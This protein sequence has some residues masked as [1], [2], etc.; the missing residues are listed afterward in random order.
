MHALAQV[1]GLLYAAEGVTLRYQTFIQSI[2]D[3]VQGLE[4]H[5][6]DP[7]E[8]SSFLAVCNMNAKFTMNASEAFGSKDCIYSYM[9]AQ[10]KVS[11]QIIDH[12]WLY[13][14][15]S[16][17]I[18]L[19]VSLGVLT[20]TPWERLLFKERPLPGMPTTLKVHPE[21]LEDAT[22]L[23]RAM[24]R[25]LSGYEWATFS[26]MHNVLV[27]QEETFKDISKLLWSMDCQ[28]LKEQALPLG[29]KIIKDG[30]LD[31]LPTPEGAGTTELSQLAEKLAILR[32]DGLVKACGSELADDID[33]LYFSLE[34]FASGR[35]PTQR[36]VQSMSKWGR[37]V[38]HR[39][40]FYLNTTVAD[41]ETGMVTT[42]FGRDAMQV[43][44]SRFRQTS[45]E[46]RTM[47]MAKPFRQFGWMLQQSQLLEVE[48][49]VDA[50]IEKYC[51]ARF[52][53]MLA[54]M[55]PT[56]PGQMALVG[57]APAASSAD[58]GGSRHSSVV[59]Q[60]LRA[61]KTEAQS[62]AD[63]SSANAQAQLL[64]MYSTRKP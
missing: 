44:W 14:V 23:R 41:E 49:L 43:L 58:P 45:V 25:V 64:R 11:I 10:M 31:T 61:P 20:R 46:A 17:M 34:S 53:P 48:E 63:L 52:K 42:V 2:N 24:T 13:R 56:D 47:E 28:F 59:L 4:E 50:G 8:Y 60:S 7:T 29:D 26:D 39:C 32:E 30:F 9:T 33:G 5:D 57:D 18:T 62:K 21:L 1:G 27:K 51:A 37:R 40:E 3:K 38:L 55:Q 35:G 54:D 36:A 16:R 19:A 6:Y 22:R 15:N 12:E